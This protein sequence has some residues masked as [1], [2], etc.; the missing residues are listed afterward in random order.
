MGST[1]FQNQNL[2][3]SESGNMKGKKAGRERE[4]GATT[5]ITTA[6]LH[7]ATVLPPKDEFASSSFGEGVGVD[8]SPC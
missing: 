3:E 5:F 8:E 6:Y 1:P 2:L 4:R 7:H